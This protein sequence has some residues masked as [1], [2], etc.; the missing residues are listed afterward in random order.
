MGAHTL[1]TVH[2]Q[3]IIIAANDVGPA[4]DGQQWLLI[5]IHVCMY[6]CVCVCCCMAATKYVTEES[7]WCVARGLCWIVHTNKVTWAKEMCYCFTKCHFT[8]ESQYKYKLL[9]G[10]SAFLHMKGKKKNCTDSNF[11][12]GNF[13]QRNTHANM[14]MYV[15]S[16]L[17][18]SLGYKMSEEHVFPPRA[19]NGTVS[20]IQ[21]NNWR[22]VVEFISMFKRTAESALNRKNDLAS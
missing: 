22:A 4:N 9:I 10:M 12:Q 8:I 18:R 21:D 1:R 14:T 16:I 11:S 13:V 19:R 5:R 20:T 15:P 2:L 3:R 17:G 6:V 7:C